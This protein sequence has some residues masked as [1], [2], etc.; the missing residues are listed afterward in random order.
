MIGMFDSGIGGFTILN[1]LK[2]I[3]PKE[4]YL[5]YADN[6]NNPYGEKSDEELFEIYDSQFFLFCMRLRSHIL[7]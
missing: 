6:K 5:Y 2:E 1:V 4:D 3:L 7:L